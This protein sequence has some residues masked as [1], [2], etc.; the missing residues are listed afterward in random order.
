[1]RSE[2]QTAARTLVRQPFRLALYVLPLGIGLGACATAFA[3]LDAAYLAPLPFREPERL[4]EIWSSVT[5][6]SAQRADLL[7]DERVSSLLTTPPSA[8]DE[9]A[10]YGWSSSVLEHAERATRVNA[11]IVTDRF[12]GVLGARPMLGSLDASGVAPTIVLGEAIWRQEFGGERSAIGATVRFQDRVYEVSAV[13]ARGAGYPRDAQLWVTGGGLDAEPAPLVWHVLARLKPAASINSLQHEL[14]ARSHAELQPDSTRF[15]GYGMAAVAL[16]EVATGNLSRIVPLT[17]AAIGIVYVGLLLNL[18]HLLFVRTLA[19]ARDTA[20]R[21]AL[22]AGRLQLIMP[23]VAETVFVSLC[24]LAIGCTLAVW[25]VML[26]PRFD[27]TLA[28]AA[29][30]WRTLAFAATLALTTALLLAPAPALRTR[31]DLQRALKQ[32]AAGGRSRGERAFR[33]VL[34]GAQ[35]AL[36][37]AMLGIVGVMLQV[38]E[39]TLALDV[40][41]QTQG[42]V[43]VR[44]DWRSDGVLDREQRQQM[45]G[46]VEAVR[47]RPGVTGAALWR[48]RSPHWPPP[49]ED[50]L[51]Q[52][53]GRSLSLSPNESL[54]SYDEVTPSYFSTIGLQLIQGRE[55]SPSDT[56]GS[57][58]VAV[59]T[60][61]A[62]RLWWPGESPLG[63]RFRLGDDASGARWLTVVG[64]I[65]D[66]TKID[67]MARALAASPRLRPSVRVYVPLA[68][69]SDEPL[70]QWAYRRCYFCSFMTLGVRTRDDGQLFASQL[71]RDVYRLS[72][73]LP[74]TV[75]QTALDEQMGVYSA[76]HLQTS[77][78][79]LGSFGMIAFMIALL[80]IAAIVGD[81]VTQRQREMGIR[82]AL[83]ARPLRLVGTTARDSLIMCAAGSVAGVACL[84]L[85]EQL[86]KKLVFMGGYGPMLLGTSA[87]DLTILLPVSVAL[88]FAAAGVAAAIAHRATR[89]DPMIIL[90]D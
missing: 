1:M 24:A 84:L 16:A 52:V 9:L 87:T 74:E 39:N 67:V 57:L 45:E 27:P 73:D 17:A 32:V 41:Y 30:D 82:I 18:A 62:A 53:E 56:E 78:R 7:A 51:L 81:G 23:S 60:A 36:A 50:Q 8:I 2:L 49:P 21:A 22:G 70:Q 83:G 55:L 71:E 12:F 58:P 72:P 63:K 13:L 48:T 11:A 89:I 61:S 77:S 6:G 37:V 29:L 85:G 20:V 25:G 40:G 5:P 28:S 80:G 65:R 69:S 26:L 54:W 44:P 68:Q 10:A 15:N 86:V 3:A 76:V 64:V 66:V 4:V 43:L 47:R 14:Q 79:L 90:Q 75:V 88:L 33:G 42:L 35:I 59:I 19:R 31:G 34:V 46:L 38:I